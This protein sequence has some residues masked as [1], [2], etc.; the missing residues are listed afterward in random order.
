MGATAGDLAGRCSKRA[1]SCKEFGMVLTSAS[2]DDKG[3]GIDPSGPG[4]GEYDNL[5]KHRELQNYLVQ[6]S[7]FYNSPYVLPLALSQVSLVLYDDFVYD[8]VFFSFL[9]RTKFNFYFSSLAFFTLDRFIHG[10]VYIIGS[11]LR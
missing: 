2:D 10:K 1:P 8:V 6:C 9:A 3:A 11:N 7:L 5:M 4:P